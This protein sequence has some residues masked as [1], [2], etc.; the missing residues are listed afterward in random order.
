MKLLIN[1]LLN[2]KKENAFTCKNYTY[3]YIYCKDIYVNGLY[4][5]YMLVV[6]K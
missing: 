2:S 6:L 5:L 3:V 1:K 4:Q